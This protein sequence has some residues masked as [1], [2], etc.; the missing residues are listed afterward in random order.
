MIRA[1]KVYK[2]ATLTIDESSVTLELDILT[3]PSLHWTLVSTAVA[4]LVRIECRLVT[5]E[6]NNLLLLIGSYP[7]PWYVPNRHV[8]GSRKATD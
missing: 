6:P 8:P 7:G 3:D 5:V 2:G 4:T 1:G